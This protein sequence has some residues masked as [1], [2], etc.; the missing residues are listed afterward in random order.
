[1]KKKITPRFVERVEEDFAA[2]SPA[3]AG[4]LVKKLNKLKRKLA[5]GE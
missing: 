1:M 5:G 3:E 2:A 4:A